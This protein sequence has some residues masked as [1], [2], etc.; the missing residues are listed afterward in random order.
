MTDIPTLVS[1][2][3]TLTSAD[4][5]DDAERKSPCEAARAAAFTSETAED[6]NHRLNRVRHRSLDIHIKWPSVPKF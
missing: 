5:G 2:L 3:E 4:L 6:S 1:Q